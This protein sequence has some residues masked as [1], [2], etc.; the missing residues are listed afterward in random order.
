MRHGYDAAINY[1]H[2]AFQFGTALL[3]LNV[4]IFSDVKPFWWQTDTAIAKNS[5]CYTENNEFKKA[6]NIVCDLVD[7]VSKNG[8]LLLNVGPKSDGTICDE[9][10]EVLKNIGSWLKVNGEAIYETDIWRYSCEGPTKVTE[11]GFNDAE[12]KVFTSEDFRFTVRGRFLYAICLNYPESGQLCV[13]SLAK[14]DASKLP[15]FNGIIKDVNVLGFSEKPLYTR[16][17]RGL[18]I[19]TNKTASKY[20]V[21]FKIEL[22]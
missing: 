16:D 2:D 3:T 7:I 8:C 17:E 20:P 1:K 10:R 19:K 18:H 21:V 22:D 9:E 11:G 15:L 4:V 14:R 5:W 13:K 6:E 12:D